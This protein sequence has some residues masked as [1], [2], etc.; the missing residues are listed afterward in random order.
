MA[1]SAANRR[2]PSLSGSSRLSLSVGKTAQA[3]QNP[4][5]HPLKHECV[6]IPTKQLSKTVLMSPSWSI[7]YVHR[8]PLAKVDYEKEI[9]RVATFGSVCPPIPNLGGVQ[10]LTIAD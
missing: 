7:S 10:I 4:N 5:R 3:T 1:Q 9:K 8:P 6:S 2:N